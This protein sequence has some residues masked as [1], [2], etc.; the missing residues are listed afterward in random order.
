M[1]GYNIEQGRFVVYLAGESQELTTTHALA[2]CKLNDIDPSN[3]RTRFYLV[4]KTP[5]LLVD[6]DVDGLIRHLQGVVPEGVDPNDFKPMSRVVENTERL[7]MALKA[8]VV[9]VAHP[10]K[11]KKGGEALGSSVLGN[12]NSSQ[13]DIV[14]YEGGAKVQC[15]NHPKA[16]RQISVTRHKG[17]DGMESFQAT[18]QKG[19]HWSTGPVWRR[20][21]G[22]RYGQARQCAE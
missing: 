1:Q 10:T 14:C 7:G 22:R 12:S 17:T 18:I 13:W 21:D 2:W 9:L 11:G 15:Q 19:G 4:P 20:E 8:P 6:T 16:I 3:A 5:N